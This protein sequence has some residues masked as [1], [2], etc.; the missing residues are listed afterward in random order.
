MKA[1]KL[2]RI[3]DLVLLLTLFISTVASHAQPKNK[4]ADATGKPNVVIIMADDLAS[5]ELSCYGGTNITT[6]HIDALAR[7][8]LR[9]RQIYASTSMCTPTR[10]SL[11]TGLYPARHGSFQNHK[12]VFDNLKSIGHYLGDL[13]YKVAL[14]GKNHSTRPRSVFPFEIIGGFQKNCV[15]KTADYTIDSL[16]SFVSSSKEP[17]CLFVMSINPHAPWTVG[18]PGEFNADKLVLPPDWVDTRETRR[19]FT[20]Y[21][22][23]VMQLDNEVG[24]VMNMLR[25]TGKDKNTLVIF[26]GEQGPQF[27]GGKWTCWDHGQKS[28]MIAWYP[29]KIQAP[30]ETDAIV[31]YEDITPTLVDFAGGKPIEGLDGTSFLAVIEGKTEKH[32]QYAYGIHNNIPEG[33]AYPMRS[34]RDD[35]YKLILNLTPEAHY[36]IK[37]TMAGKNTMLWDSWLEKAQTSEEAKFITRR[38]TTRPPVEFYDIS[39]DPWELK[40]L[41][42]DP[43]H[44]AR[45]KTLTDELRRWMNQQGDE[46]APMDKVYSKA[47][48]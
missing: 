36:K 22:A 44:A 34:I 27:L 28:S 38:L 4:K 7:Q 48:H 26:L 24:A 45:I 2:N 33:P 8:G 15:S 9:F 20:K 25:A 43:A 6:P 5:S 10:A 46:G 41:A 12:A 39:T 19:Q 16:T 18:N 29:G 17:F 32:R 31:Q 35:R 13:G 1:K 3:V 40:N 11:F 47:G 37:Y 42:A 30:R 23:E 14:T 21:L